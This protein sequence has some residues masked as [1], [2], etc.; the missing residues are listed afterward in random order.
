MTDWSVVGRLVGVGR[1]WSVGGSVVGSSTPPV[2][3]R[4]PHIPRGTP[5]SGRRATVPYVRGTWPVPENRR[6]RH[7]PGFMAFLTSFYAVSGIGTADGRTRVRRESAN[8]V[9]QGY[10]IQTANQGQLTRYPW[11]S[12]GQ[13]RGRLLPDWQPYRSRTGPKSGPEVVPW[14]EYVPW[15]AV[16]GVFGWSVVG[17]LSVGCRSSVVG[18]TVSLPVV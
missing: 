13:R 14:L 16:L 7:D 11:L 1:W 17:R 15:L 12:S 2:P 3:P 10:R 4:H 9:P 8:R 6:S 5:L 18:R